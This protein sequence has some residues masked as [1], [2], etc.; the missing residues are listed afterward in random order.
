MTL[1]MIASWS[2]SVAN[3]SVAFISRLNDL[4]RPHFLCPFTHWW[5][6]RF[7]NIFTIVNRAAGSMEEQKSLW[8]S[9]DFNY[10]GYRY[11]YIHVSVA[12]TKHLHAEGEVSS[13]LRFWVAQ[14][15]HGLQTPRQKQDDRREWWRR[16]AQPV[17]SRKQRAK[18]GA[19]PGHIRMTCLH[20]ALFPTSHEL[21]ST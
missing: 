4:C 7:C 16:D 3:H 6:F 18:G 13:G 21:V 10:F 15:M 12:G 17:E 2:I 14:C 11:I 5:T 20:Q 8:N 9:L 1:S 19:L